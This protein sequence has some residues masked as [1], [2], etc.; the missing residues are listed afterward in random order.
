[1]SHEFLPL[2]A[3]AA[4]QI[5]RMTDRIPIL[6][7]RCGIADGDILASRGLLERVLNE[8]A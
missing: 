6:E 4:H 3:A 5:H 2:A 8:G 1:M 7:L